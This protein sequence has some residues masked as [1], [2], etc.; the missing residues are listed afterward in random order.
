VNRRPTLDADHTDQLQ[1]RGILDC[2]AYD[3]SL[4]LA[5]P[6]LA[7]LPLGPPDPRDPDAPPSFAAVPLQGRISMVVTAGLSRLWHLPYSHGGF[8]D[9]TEFHNM[10]ACGAPPY[11]IRRPSGPCR[12]QLGQLRPPHRRDRASGQQLG[13]RPRPG[14]PMGRFPR[15]RAIGTLTRGPGDLARRGGIQLARN[16][17]RPAQR[18]HGGGAAGD[19]PVDATLPSRQGRPARADDPHQRR[20]RKRAAR[21]FSEKVAD[22]LNSKGT[23]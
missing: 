16:P 13:A 15:D 23:N 6:V 2:P 14:A 17:R 9:G 7:N 18:R 19:D 5:T 21:H 3:A 20:V 12:R 4:D 22:P 1:R 8:R 11:G 10:S